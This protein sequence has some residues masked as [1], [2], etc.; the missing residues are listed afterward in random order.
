MVLLGIAVLAGNPF[1]YQ[2]FAE[3]I[4]VGIY[5]LCMIFIFVGLLRSLIRLKG[6]E[7]NTGDVDSSLKKI[8]EIYESPEKYLHNALR[9]LLFSSVVLFPLSFLPRKI[10]SLG[11]TSALQDTLITIVLSVIILYVAYK[12]GAFKDTNIED[13]RRYREEL[14]SLKSSSEELRFEV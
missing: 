13:F 1:D 8:I 5:T 14:I 6:V 10:E 2:Q 9:L 11:W 12:L 3:F 4:P 7:I